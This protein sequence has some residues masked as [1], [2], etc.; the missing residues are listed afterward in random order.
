MSKRSGCTERN[1]VTIM[2]ITNQVTESHNLCS[3][4]LLQPLILMM[5]VGSYSAQHTTPPNTHTHTRENLS[6]AQI[7]FPR[8][9]SA[10]KCAH[11]HTRTHADAHTH[12]RY[13]T[14]VYKTPDPWKLF[15]LCSGCAACARACERCVFITFLI[16]VLT[17][18]WQ[19]L[20]LGSKIV[21]KKK[22][23]EN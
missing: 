19:K 1:H 13:L 3:T 17:F 18:K 15:Q 4:V 11:T 23:L 12:T 8:E 16:K 2:I 9:Q 7:L 21:V 5:S 20:G 10:L 6:L 14:H 22:K